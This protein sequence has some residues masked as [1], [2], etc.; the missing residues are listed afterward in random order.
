V[1]AL[2]CRKLFDGRAVHSAMTDDELLAV[3]RKNRGLSS[4]EADRG[5]CDGRHGRTGRT[6]RPP[7]RLKL[8][9]VRDVV[10]RQLLLTAA[11]FRN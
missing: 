9:P 1:R 5:R 3:V 6:V 8:T 10:F 11:R 7:A 2:S 4:S